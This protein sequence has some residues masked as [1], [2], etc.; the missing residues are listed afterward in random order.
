MDTGDTFSINPKKVRYSVCLTNP[1]FGIKSGLSAGQTQLLNFPTSN[2]QL[3][4]LQ[5][6]YQCLKPDGRAAV[7]VPEN[8][9]FEGGIG[10]AVRTRLLDQFNLH[11]VLRL[12]AGIFYATGVRTAVLFFAR[13]T[14]TT[15]T[16]VYDLR[17]Y[18]GHF[19]KRRQL[20]HVHLEDFVTAY[21]AD[22]LG[23]ARRTT[24]VNFH[25]FSREEIRAGKDRLDL[26]N[27]PG[28]FG[29]T[30]SPI[31]LLELVTMELEGAIEA[32]REMR[33][34]LDGAALRE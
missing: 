17:S 18:G 10:A 22:P 1:P 34:L 4:F 28:H 14:S 25:A 15:H 29:T 2:K 31:A 13:T 7:I 9:L 24:T 33:A 11:T 16:W 21:G 3:A 30:D 20:E 5:H 23:G 8:V 6:I 26:E 12:P 19:T 32:A 27:G